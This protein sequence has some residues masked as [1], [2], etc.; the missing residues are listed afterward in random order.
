MR[1]W[2]AGPMVAVSCL[3]AGVWGIGAGA[4]DEIE[5]EL[6]GFLGQ[7]P[8][9]GLRLPPAGPTAATLEV[10]TSLRSSRCGFALIATSWWPRTKPASCSGRIFA[11]STPP[12]SGGWVG[13]YT[14]GLR[15]V[16]PVLA[17]EVTSK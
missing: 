15:R 14:G 2:L 4:A 3:L 11:A 10:P 6:V 8:R 17:V 7:L 16:P 5:A 1:T 13:H 9:D 12:C